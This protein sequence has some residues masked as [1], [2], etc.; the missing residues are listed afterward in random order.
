ME[1][2]IGIVNIFS[3]TP[4]LKIHQRSVGVYS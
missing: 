2:E 3:S 4:T 1:K